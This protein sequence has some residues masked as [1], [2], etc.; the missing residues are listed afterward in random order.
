MKRIALLPR[1][2][3]SIFTAG[4]VTSRLALFL[5]AVLLLTCRV[6]SAQVTRGTITGIVVDPSGAI[7]PGAQ[8]EVV[9]TDTGSKTDIVSNKTGEYTVPYL[10]PGPYTVT[11]NAPGFR[12]FVRSGLVLET[13]QTITINVKLTVGQASEVMTVQGDTPLVDTADSNTG[14]TLTSEEVEDLP[15]NGRNALGF[16]HLEY[17]A[18]AK[19]KHSETQTLPFGNSTADDFSLGGGNS[20]SNEILLN[21]VPNMEDGSRTAGYSPLL[22]AVDAVRVD[23]FSANAA[24]GDTAGGIVNITTKAGTN[25]IHGSLSE[26]YEGSRP[27]QAKPYFTPAGTAI[28][29]THDDQ[30]GATIGGPIVI[31]HLY[32]GRDKLFFFYAFEGYKGKTPATAILS[33]PTAAERTGDFSALLADDTTSSPLAGVIYNPYTAVTNPTTGVVTRTAIPGNILSKAGLSVS[34][35]AEAYMNMIPL[36]NYTGAATTVDG[37]NNYFTADPT[38]NNYESNQGRIDYN[39]A[40]L[41]KIFVEGHRSKYVSNS[42]DYFHNALTGTN[43]VV[44]LSGGQVDDVQNFNATTALEFR[45]GFSRYTNYSEPSAIGLNPT[46]VGFPSTLTANSTQLALPVLTFSDSVTTIPS[47]GLSGPPGNQERFDNIQLYASLNKTLGHHTIKIGPDIRANKNSSLSPG[48]ADGTFAFKSS[49]GDYLTGSSA[50]STNSSV[51]SSAVQPFGGAFALFAL[52]LPTS[53]SYAVNTKFQY[54]N[55]YFGGFAQ[56]DWK[57]LANM[58]ISLGIRLE[59][60]TPVDESHNQME[61]GWNPTQANATTVPATTAYTAAANANLAVSAFQPT[62]ALIYG[63]PS[64][65]GAYNTAPIYVSPRLGFAFSPASSHGSLAIRGGAGIYVNPFGDYS[66]GNS[67]GYSQTTSLITTTNNQT[68]GGTL[69][70]PFDPVTNPIQLPLGNA[71]GINTQLGSSLSFNA[72]VKVP[73]AEKWTLDVQKQ[74]GRSFMVEVGYIGVHQVHNS[75]SNTIS[76]APILPYLS[77]SPYGNSAQTAAA[78]TLLTGKVTNPFKGTMTAYGPAAVTSLNTSSTIT[79]SQLLQAYPEYSGVTETLVPG[80]SGNFNA[81][82]LKVTHRMSHGLQ[83]NFNYEHSRQLGATGS[84]N[85][86]YAGPLWYGLTTSDFPDHASVTS[87]Y[88]LPFG[89]GR[90]F[91]NQ[92][93]LWDEIAGGWS[94]TTI[95]QFLSGTPDSWG[96]VIYTGNYSGFNNKPH[97]GMQT[98]TFSFTG[99]D[100]VSADQPGTYNLRT[101]PQYL[102]RDDHTNNF[103]FSILKNFTLHDRIILQP[104]VDA[105]NAFNRPQ[106]NAPNLTP[107]SSSFGKITSQLNTGRQLQGGVHIT[108]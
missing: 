30:Y 89:R 72:A 98:P 12:E 102:L 32:N 81:L 4:K 7:I 105:F 56:D 38:V 15:S 77:T 104:R 68:I 59:S 23:E 91:L 78:Q 3:T 93:R 83:F 17:G 107:T 75:F 35:I 74:F 45:V 84:L 58:T 106:F 90:Q 100:Q 27:F 92:S 5:A 24:Y 14:Q 70:D 71:E 42:A 49:T 33:V 65:R 9:K 36:P 96:N 82:L 55:F 44:I 20:A 73:Y 6:L 86:N 19:G 62:G 108:F 2:E 29:S 16:A 63:S 94:L 97:N 34:P 1:S 95:Y 66:A 18:V 61:V 40:R 64:R 80:A 25:Q 13:E 8:I 51:P 39:I 57:I 103:D 79:V 99:F 41:N 47:P 26:Y 87:I 88:Q 54:N 46:S 76:G 21:G 22:E 101:F 69:A 48:A 31:P 37:Q 52:G 85:P 60:E 43:S 50:T 67:Y 28:A 10:E 53:G 11:V